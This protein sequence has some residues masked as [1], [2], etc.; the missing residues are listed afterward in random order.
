MGKDIENNNAD[1]NPA[2]VPP[3]TLTS[4]NITIQVKEPKT[5]GNKIVKS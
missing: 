1:N 4:A 5:T 3:I 2:V